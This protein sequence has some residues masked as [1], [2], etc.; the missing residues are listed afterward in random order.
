V[1]VKAGAEVFPFGWR[2]QKGNRVAPHAALTFDFSIRNPILPLKGAE[3]F[4]KTR[5]RIGLNGY[6]ESR[7]ESN[8]STTIAESGKCAGSGQSSNGT[9]ATPPSLGS[10]VEVGAYAPI[11]LPGLRKIRYPDVQSPLFVAPLLKYGQILRWTAPPIGA[12]GS[13]PHRYHFIGSRIGFL[14]KFDGTDFEKRR[15]PP[16]LAAYFDIGAGRFGNLPLLDGTIPWK[17]SVTGTFMLPR[18]PFYFGVN[19]NQGGGVD[20]TR[21]FVGIRDELFD[22]VFRGMKKRR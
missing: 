2:D 11:F 13:V 14:R 21:I 12:L 7:I 10:V 17:F 22:R 16:I 5:Y 8:V 15:V 19:A 20:D 9:C 3:Q 1:Y 6:A 4:V 18:L